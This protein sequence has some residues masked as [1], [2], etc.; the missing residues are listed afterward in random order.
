MREKKRKREPEN[1]EKRKRMSNY[2]RLKQQKRYR[3]IKTGSQE[4]EPKMLPK[5]ILKF[6]FLKFFDC[7][8][9]FMGSG[10]R[11][12]V[13]TIEINNFDFSTHVTVNGGVI[14]LLITG[15][16]IFFWVVWFFFLEKFN[17]HAKILATMQLNISLWLGRMGNNSL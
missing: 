9:F 12:V 5:R 4:N 16:S 17:F 7:S 14:V 1:G 3:A 11:N 8:V 13:H 15:L 10:N 2:V 6:I